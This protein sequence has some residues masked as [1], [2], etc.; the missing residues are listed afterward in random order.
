MKNEQFAYAEKTLT[1]KLITYQ[2]ALPSSVSPNGSRRFLV[3]T[4]NKAGTTLKGDDF[5]NVTVI[6]LD[7]KEETINRTLRWQGID[8]IG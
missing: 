8:L 6:D 5:V 1:G 4:V 2:T 7:N 3:K